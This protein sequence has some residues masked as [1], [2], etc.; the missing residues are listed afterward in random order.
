VQH[1][2]LLP[3]CSHQCPPTSLSAFKVVFSPDE[4]REPALLPCSCLE[5]K[6]PVSGQ[7]RYIAEKIG[8]WVL[9][10]TLL[11]SIGAT[12]VLQMDLVE[13]FQAVC[14]CNAVL[15]SHIACMMSRYRMV[16][17]GDR[18]YYTTGETAYPEDHTELE[19]KEAVAYNRCNKSCWHSGGGSLPSEQDL[20]SC[21]QAL[22]HSPLHDVTCSQESFLQEPGLWP[23]SLLRGGPPWWALCMGR[24]TS[25]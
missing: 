6:R 4:D 13:I 8:C 15:T 23:S 17:A 11:L 19:T 10:L 5:T 14:L 21:H 7:G 20:S 9:S 18:N 3:R 24:T 2:S 12:D 22:A 1:V 16:W 25:G